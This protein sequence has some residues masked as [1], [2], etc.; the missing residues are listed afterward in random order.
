MIHVAT[1]EGL[2]GPE[3]LKARKLYRALVKHH[4]AAACA[5]CK[6]YPK[7][8]SMIIAGDFFEHIR[9]IAHTPITPQ[10]FFKL[11]H[12]GLIALEEVTPR[13][14]RMVFAEFVREEPQ[15]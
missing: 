11:Q 10:D 5:T 13:M 2:I 15:P 6:S 3:H 7:Y 14:V 8:G 12:A 9:D 1:Q 4:K